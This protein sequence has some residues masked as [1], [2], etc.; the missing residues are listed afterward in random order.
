M[1]TWS[2][3]RV[4]GTR[5]GGSGQDPAVSIRTGRSSSR[6]RPRRRAA[7]STPDLRSGRRW[8]ALRF[9]PAV[10]KVARSRRRRPIRSP[11]AFRPRAAKRVPDHRPSP[12][13]GRRDAC[14]LWPPIG[15]S[16]PAMPTRSSSSSTK[17]STAN[18]QRPTIGRPNTRPGGRARRRADVAASPGPGLPRS[19]SCRP[20]SESRRCRSVPCRTGTS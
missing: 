20:C 14:R 3:L 10:A 9:H 5:A 4:R 13:G 15:A 16:R 1:A 12:E 19:R 11:R 18:A 7:T 2:D 8:R 17:R 6:D